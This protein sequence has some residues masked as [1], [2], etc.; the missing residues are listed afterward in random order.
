MPVVKLTV[1]Y[2]GTNYAGWQVQPDRPTVQSVMERA[3]LKLTGFPSQVLSAGRT[4]SGVHALGQVAS[5]YTTANIPGPNWRPALQNH[6]P[7]DVVIRDSEIA[8]DNFHAT[9][10]AIRKRYRYLIH[11]GPVCLPF[12]RNYVHH[13]RAPLSAEAMHS[14]AQQLVGKHDFR[15]FETDWPNKATS[16]RTIEEIT[17]RRASDWNLWTVDA[18]QQPPVDETG[19]FIHMDIVADGFLYN[20]VRTIMG[21][22]LHVGRGAWP[23][24][25]IA[26]VLLAQDRTVAGNTAPA[27]GLYLVQVDYPVSMSNDAG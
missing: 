10:S 2:D 11:N 1:A 3:V 9:F 19:E 23:A 13:V 22:L 17:I 5:F 26:Q 24:E 27:S 8:P 14:A 18:L 4:D 25:R 7:Y 6:L 16:V 15:S 21:T 20:M 12:L